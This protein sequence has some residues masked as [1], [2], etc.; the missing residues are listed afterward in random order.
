MKLLLARAS[1][2]EKPTETTLEAI[3]AKV[4]AS[5]G[6]IFY[7]DKANSDKVLLALIDHF[8]AKGLSVY[9]RRVKYGLEEGE[10]MYEVH[11]L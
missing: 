2:N 9:H 6:H 4:E 8:D 5:G 10:Y 3:E 1:L 7:F 11:I